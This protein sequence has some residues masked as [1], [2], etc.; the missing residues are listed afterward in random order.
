VFLDGHVDALSNSTSRDILRMFSAI[1]DGD[2]PSDPGD[3]TDLN[4]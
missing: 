3:G 4:Y 2:D 1:G